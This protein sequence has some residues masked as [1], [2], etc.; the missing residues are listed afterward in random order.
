MTS[1]DPSHNPFREKAQAVRRPEAQSSPFPDDVP[2]LS[3]RDHLR[4]RKEGRKRV[5]AAM[6]PLPDLRF[7]QSYLLS[8]RPFLKPRPTQQ[9]KAEK[10]EVTDDKIGS[11]TVQGAESDEVF[12]W[13]R[14]VDVD[15]GQVVW[16]TFR[17]Q[18][19]SPLV[20]GALWGWATVFLSAT[21]VALRASMYPA[22]HTPK[23]RIAGGPGGTTSQA[24]GGDAVGGTGWWRNWVK[25][26]LGGVETAAV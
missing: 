7:E 10:G 15:W 5:K 22:R 19:F 11:A 9:A 8:I 1:L 2:E 18:L 4:A 16:V 14:E 23:G 12:H 20:Q 24:G 25:S 13:G 17:D 3:H 21:G 6:P 26:W